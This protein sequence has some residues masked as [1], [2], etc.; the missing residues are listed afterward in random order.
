[1]YPIS[2]GWLRDRDEKKNLRRAPYEWKKP[3][4]L[5]DFRGICDSEKCN[6]LQ[7]LTKKLTWSGAQNMHLNNW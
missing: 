3:A 1:M 7:I 5:L 6:E 2:E 4:H